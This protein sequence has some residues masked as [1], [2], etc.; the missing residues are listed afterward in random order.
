MNEVSR[1]RTY[2]DELDKSSD[3]ANVVA[4]L[5]TEENVANRNRMKKSTL[6]DYVANIYTDAEEQ[7][8]VMTVMMKYLKTR[9]QSQM[10]KIVGEVSNLWMIQ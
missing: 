10:K 8:R 1:I 3:L 6:Y 5:L 7:I 2:A 9:L 4:W